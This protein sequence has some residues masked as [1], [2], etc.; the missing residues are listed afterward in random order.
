MVSDITSSIDQLC[1]RRKLDCLV[2]RV[3]DA[4]AVRCSP[5]LVQGLLAAVKD[6]EQVV[7]KSKAEMCTACPLSQ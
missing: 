5:A 1:Q 3:H 7:N 4:G 6:S 2:D